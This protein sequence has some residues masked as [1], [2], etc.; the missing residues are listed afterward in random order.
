MAIFDSSSLARLTGVDVA[1]D[2]V[3]ASFRGLPELAYT[4]LS[5]EH[6]AELVESI[7]QTIAT[8]DFR[9]IGDQDD[10]AIWEKGWQEVAEQITAAPTVD[11]E[12]LKP[13]Y[14]DH[15]TPFRLFGDYV[16]PGTDFFEY[17]VGIAVRKLLI[18]RFLKDCNSLLELGCGTGLNLLLAA[19]LFEDAALAGSDWTAATGDL[20]GALG[21]AK[22]RKIDAYHYNMLT[23]DGRERL[24]ITPGTDILTVHA[25]EQLG[26]RGRELLDYVL[27]CKPRRVLHLEPMAEF[28]DETVPFDEIALRYHRKRGY[29]EGLVPFIRE[30]VVA[31]EIEVLGQHRVLL[32]NTYHE[33][34]SYIAWKPAT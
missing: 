15:A 10:Q 26:R 9:V 1:T 16:Y 28:Y 19:D 21:R 6:H 34:Y 24:R 23:G 30:K 29:I 31:G 27:S 8:V 32:G 7:E 22:G 18:G 20:L 3:L 14:Y 2:E 17:Y 12:T 5:Q 11:I 25:L 13:Q 4:P 33:A